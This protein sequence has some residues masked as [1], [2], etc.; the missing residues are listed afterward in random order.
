[1]KHPF[2]KALGS[3]FTLAIVLSVF[4][5][6]AIAKESNPA[7]TLKATTYDWGEAITSVVID[8]GEKVDAS[9]VDAKD[10]TYTTTVTYFSYST[11][12][13]VTE[14]VIR[15]ID[16]VTVEG[17]KITLH[18]ITSFSDG[19][20]VYSD[21]TTN[22][23]ITLV[24]EI[25]KVSGVAFDKAAAYS[26]TGLISPSVDQFLEEKTT[27]LNYRLY[28]PDSDQKEALVVWLHGGGE[29]GTDNRKQIAANLVTGWTT[30]EAQAALDTAYILA[31]QTSSGKH[32]PTYIMEAILQVMKEHQIDPK[33]IYVGGC[34]MGG[35]GTIDVITAYPK[36]FAAAFPICPA[37]Q[38]SEEAATAI[39]SASADY[40]MASMKMKD[41]PVKHG[42][43][44]VYFI[45]SIDDNTCT[46]ANSILSY[47]RLVAAYAKLGIAAK[48]APVYITFFKKV[49]FNGM[50][51]A[52]GPYLG[53]WSWVYVHNNFDCEGY[54]Y[55][56][57]NYL[58]TEI[59]VPKTDKSPYY[60]KNGLV[61]F[62][63]KKT[64]TYYD[65]GKGPELLTDNSVFT[66]YGG[67][68][69]YDEKKA[70]T[71][72]KEEWITAPSMRLTDITDNAC[73]SYDSF[74]DWLSDQVVETVGYTPTHPAVTVED[75]YTEY[76]YQL[77][78][79]LGNDNKMNYYLYDPVAHGADPNG[80]YPLIVIFHGAGNG[81]EGN[82]CCS[83]TDMAVY[84]TPEYQ[85]KF[86]DQAAYILFPKANE[87]VADTG[88]TGTWMTD[89]DNDGKSDYNAAVKGIIDEV[90][91]NNKQINPDNVAVG[92]T[93]A[94][95]YMT[96]SLLSDYADNFAAAFLIAGAKIPT[97]EE[98]AW[99]D[100]LELPIWIVQG[101]NDEL[102]KYDVFIKPILD[103]LENMESVRVTSLKWLRYG[104]YSLAY[105]PDVYTGIQMSQ[106]L[107]LWALGS[108]LIYDDGTPYDRNYPEGF[109]AWLN[110]YF[111]YAE[112]SDLYKLSGNVVKEGSYT[113][114]SG[115]TL[116]S[117]AEQY[118]GKASDWKLI[119]E[120]N[121]ALLSDPDRIYIGQVLVIPKAK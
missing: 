104:D 94:G 64:I 67:T 90:V 101:V 33:R 112:N 45:H 56:G 117:I 99:Y 35:M 27:H 65:F 25:R 12:S 22:S 7:Y 9:T 96:W 30:T 52:M 16:Y 60:V 74:F 114:I 58:S 55:D 100:K 19:C 38:L 42:S 50:P 105:L 54:D 62:L 78:E 63:Y 3:L 10:F 79:T 82:K 71:T 34:S 110:Q 121:K 95:G 69:V 109:I 28:V 53:H 93:S 85:A 91:K 115:D 6:T 47:Q 11:Y 21:S 120:A 116:S 68:I 87:Y 40:S 1:M 84:A 73:R 13:N 80:K 39:A 43:T 31:P 81:M 76:T 106:H 41:I 92:G 5:N 88:R 15:Q 118:T 66:K 119:Y 48:D 107:A 24:G 89:D 4:T 18:L 70:T 2:T 83:Y 86:A 111:K 29:F 59:D 49:D 57:Q 51:E 32:N 26:C 102:V 37:S 36:F 77:K 20:K 103:T 98:L 17:S 113:V 44:A 108:N 97:Q 14:E 72:T 23:K 75:Y 61:Y 46:P 8:M